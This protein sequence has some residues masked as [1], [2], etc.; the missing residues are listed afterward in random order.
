M[1]HRILPPVVTFHI[2]QSRK[3]S[4]LTSSRRPTYGCATRPAGDANEVHLVSGMMAN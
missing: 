2:L 3:E 4:T 1:S